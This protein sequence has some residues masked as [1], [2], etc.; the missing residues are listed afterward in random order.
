MGGHDEVDKWIV[1]SGEGVGELFEEVLRRQ[2]SRRGLI[3][4]ATL[5]TTVAIIG[6]QQVGPEEAA[7]QSAALG[8]AVVPPQPPSVD[9]IL[10]PQG[11][12]ARTLIRWGEPLTVSAPAHDV[13]NQ[14]RAAQEQ[15]FGYN[16]DF[17]GF[18]P[19]PMGSSASDRGLLAVNHEYTNEEL[20]FPGYN[21]NS[22]TRTQV[23]VAMAAHGLSVVEV[24]RTPD[25]SWSYVRGSPYNR[26]I[27]AFTP[28]RIAGPAAGHDWM[29]TSVNPSATEVLGMLNNCAAGKTPWGTVL[30]SEENFHQYFAN[31]G[32]LDQ[33]DPRVWVHTR[34]GVP[35]E[36]SERKWERYHSRFDLSQEPNEAFRFGWMVE[37][38]PYDQ[39]MMP[40]KRTA[41]GR[42][43]HE[44]AT[45][46]IAPSGQVA[47]YMGD[48]SQFEYVYKFVSKGRYNPNDRAAN[49]GLLD[50]GTLYVAKFNDD[51]TGAWLPLIWGQGPLRPENGF[52]SQG[53]VLV[54]T[55][56]AADAVGATKMD[57]PEDVEPNPVTKKIYISLTNNAQ[58]G[59]E[60]REGP[61]AS[62][63]RAN[64]R[65]GHII[66]L[67]EP[68]N[69]HAS[70]T[71]RW[72][73]FILAGLP[74][75]PS[76][77]YGGFNKSRVSPV[78]S[79][80][81][82]AFD[83]AGNLWIAT[84]GAASAIKYNDG[85]F[86]VPV[87][88]PN[89]GRTQQFVSSVTG[90]EVCGPEFTS[91]NSTLFLAIQHPGEGSTFEAPSSTWPDRVGLPRPSVI[92]IRAWDSRRIGS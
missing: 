87:S 1:R 28:M 18:F 15:Q 38:D 85:L 41:L 54:K 23:E 63:P 77:Y 40:V 24:Q 27:T 69:D 17:I 58:R 52:M 3:K 39:T 89:R 13:W 30:T 55:R 91:D 79:P 84:D 60:G 12:Y 75:D 9:E 67:T 57:R 56:L 37:I 71:F 10:V 4:G 20:M 29:R 44:A 88:G 65:A 26:R 14:T 68:N 5:A 35:V 11:Y 80:D 90:S 53:D 6:S 62:N 66:E 82:V 61:T 49:F 32:R 19:L 33:S 72:E 31:L 86:A 43:R 21:A 47:A 36:A 59:A 92:Y 46:G 70:T 16:C 51:G 8:F 2:L 74:D 34:Y 76:S 22:P 83:N 48:D 42:F 64:N 50:E 81:N 78:G 73:I 25:G 7:A 45:I